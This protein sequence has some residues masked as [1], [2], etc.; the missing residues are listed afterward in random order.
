[1]GLMFQRFQWPVLE[2]VLISEVLCCVRKLVIT[3]NFYPNQIVT[4]L[5]ALFEHFLPTL[6]LQHLLMIVIKQLLRTR[7]NF[8]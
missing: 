6:F 7:P 3:S 5:L 1:M 8:L 4:I 2:R